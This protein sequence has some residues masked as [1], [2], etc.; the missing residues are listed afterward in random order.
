VKKN[1]ERSPRWINRSIESR[2]KMSS[3]T[4]KLNV[5]LVANRSSIISVSKNVQRCAD[6][7]SNSW[8]GYP[9]NWILI[10][11]LH[12]IYIINCTFKSCSSFLPETVTL[13]LFWF[14]LK[15]ICLC[16]IYYFS[17]NQSMKLLFLDSRSR[18]YKTLNRIK[19]IQ[20]HKW[21]TNNYKC[22]I[23]RQLYQ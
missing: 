14:L 11:C 9:D 20:H 19:H 6:T 13:H 21:N 4:K 22:L 23:N 3:R 18:S 1:E 2:H 7:D 16:T 12:T 15:I 17:N 10:L 8:I 5:D